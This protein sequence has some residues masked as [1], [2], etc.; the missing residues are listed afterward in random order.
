MH[1]HGKEVL[2]FRLIAQ[3]A[4]TFGGNPQSRVRFPH[5]F[6]TVPTLYAQVPDPML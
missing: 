4:A 2:D 3:C 6:R 5:L 1:N